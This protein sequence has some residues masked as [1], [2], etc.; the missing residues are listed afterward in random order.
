MNRR[1]SDI[2]LAPCNA[3]GDVEASANLA[4]LQLV[5]RRKAR[6]IGFVEIGNRGSK[7]IYFEM[8]HAEGRNIDLDDP[9][10][11]SNNPMLREGLTL[12]WIGWQF[13]VPVRN[14]HTLKL[15]VPVAKH[16]DDSP[17]YG[18]VRSD[19]TIDERRTSL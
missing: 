10:S 5:D 4:V 6:K 3:D 19:W 14:E 12:I 9:E 15:T 11:F 1:I 17:I 7:P 16:A 2:T 8:N 18:L 13:D